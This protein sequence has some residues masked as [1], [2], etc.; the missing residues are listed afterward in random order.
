M[1]DWI[2]VTLILNKDLVTNSKQL[3]QW[4]LS[5]EFYGLFAYKNGGNTEVEKYAENQTLIFM[6][7]LTESTLKYWLKSC[8]VF[9]LGFFF[10]YVCILK[11]QFKK[12]LSNFCQKWSKFI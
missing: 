12:N 10:L 5:W 8:W 6:T 1:T 7:W 3:Q 9:L 2:P 11:Q 4:L